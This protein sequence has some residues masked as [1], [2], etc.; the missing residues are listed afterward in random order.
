MLLGCSVVILAIFTLE[1]DIFEREHS[2]GLYGPTAYFISKLAV[3]LPLYIISPVALVAIIYYT[4]ALT[5][6]ADHLF[7]MALIIAVLTA[8]G[9]SIGMAISNMFKQ[10]IVALSMAP[11]IILPFIIFSG[12]VVNLEQLPV[13]I[14]WLQWL[15]PLKYG[16]VALMTNELESVDVWCGSSVPDELCRPIPGQEVLKALGLEGQGTI[17]ENIVAMIGFCVLFLCISYLGLRRAAHQR[18]A[19][20]RLKKD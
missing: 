16:Y 17:W 9:I 12:Q 15:S 6:G 11:I 2:A 4:V 5:P 8:V 20:K 18:R 10:L 7:M 19:G 1:R 13:G 14:R 3:N